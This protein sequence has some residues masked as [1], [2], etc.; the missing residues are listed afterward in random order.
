MAD[1]HARKEAEAAKE[2]KE[3]E[4]QRERDQVAAQAVQARIR[5]D[6]TVVRRGEQGYE[7]AEEEGLPAYHV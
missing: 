7:E 5:R 6:G 3:A 2:R 1:A 4:A